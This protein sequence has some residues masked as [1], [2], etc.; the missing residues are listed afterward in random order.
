MEVKCPVCGAPLEGEVC[1]YCGHKLKTN[2]NNSTVQTQNASNINFVTN[3]VNNNSVVN[4]DSQ[5]ISN[6]MSNVSKK[7]KITALILCVLFGFLGVHRFY[8]GKIGT[9]LLY[10]CTFGLFFIGYIVDIILII[11]GKFTDK[12]GL[13]LR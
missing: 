5:N 8:V 9:G 2:T 11:T 10:L 4:N 7:N 13:E 1:T 6:Q 3:V 12:F